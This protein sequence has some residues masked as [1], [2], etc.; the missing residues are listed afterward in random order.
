MSVIWLDPVH[1]P[2]PQAQ[3]QV[4]GGDGTPSCMIE[5]SESRAY[6][7]A[8]EILDGYK[9][10]GNFAVDLEIVL[11]NLGVR[12]KVTFEIGPKSLLSDCR[13]VEF[14]ANSDVPRDAFDEIIHSVRKQIGFDSALPW[15]VRFFQ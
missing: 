14:R 1:A 13:H 9:L 6:D 3:P 8:L 4:A 12:D 15:W 2:S 5:V 10:T 11:R 7:C